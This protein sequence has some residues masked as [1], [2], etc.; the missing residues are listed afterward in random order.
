MQRRRRNGLRPM[1]PRQALTE[2]FAAA[3]EGC[4]DTVLQEALRRGMESLSQ[5]EVG[6]ALQVY[7]NMGQLRQVR[8]AWLSSAALQRSLMLYQQ[9]PPHDL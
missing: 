1:C 6:S 2:Q 7:F 4:G 3:N 9:E 8:A 5:A